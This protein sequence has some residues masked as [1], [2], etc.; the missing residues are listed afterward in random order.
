MAACD[1]V[2]YFPLV[3]IPQQCDDKAEALAVWEWLNCG[4]LGTFKKRHELINV[5]R[6]YGLAQFASIGVNSTTC[7]EGPDRRYA[8]KDHRPGIIDPLYL[9]FQR[10]YISAKAEHLCAFLGIDRFT[11][12][13]A[14][15]KVASVL[16][17]RDERWRSL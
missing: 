2:F 15:A 12:E 7:L 1:E 13:A 9:R 6:Q 8:A 11:R 16:A 3:V 5:A 14:A 17:L 10:R 4:G